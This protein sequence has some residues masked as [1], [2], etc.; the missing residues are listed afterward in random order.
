MVAQNGQNKKY[1]LFGSCSNN[2]KIYIP[3]S[4]IGGLRHANVV[5]R[6][7]SLSISFLILLYSLGKLFLPVHLDIYQKFQV[8]NPR[9]KSKPLCQ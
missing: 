8:N 7:M 6:N 1:H 2:K 4:G 3:S 9:G 5:F